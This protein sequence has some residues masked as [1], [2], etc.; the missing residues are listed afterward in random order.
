MAVNTTKIKP[1]ADISGSHILFPEGS[2]AAYL[3]VNEEVADD[4]STYILHDGGGSSGSSDIHSS[5]FKLTQSNMP[6]NYELIAASI[7]LRGKAEAA[8]NGTLVGGSISCTVKMNGIEYSFDTFTCTSSNYSVYLAN[9]SD[10]SFITDFNNYLRTNNKSPEI[11][12]S[13]FTK[14]NQYE[15]GTKGVVWGSVRITQV[16]MSLTYD[17][18]VYRKIGDNWMRV[19]E[20]YRKQNG[21]WFEIDEDEFKSIIQSNL[22]VDKCNL[23]GHIEIPLLDI[24]AACLT[25]GMTGGK[26]CSFCNKILKEHDSILPA[27]GHNSKESKGTATCTEDGMIGGTE[28]S[29]C[30]TVLTEHD[31]VQPALGHNEVTIAGTA[32]CTEDGMQGGTKC[33]RC[34]LTLKE[35]DAVQPALGHNFSNVYTGQCSRCSEYDP[36]SL[37]F[38]IQRNTQTSATTYHFMPNLTWGEW[39]KKDTNNIFGGWKVDVNGSIRYRYTLLGTTDFTVDNV[40]NTDLIIAGHAY[41]ATDNI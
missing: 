11:E 24:P 21:G 12:L 14:P 13:I 39:V 35:H 27:L 36:N 18:G 41:T 23:R 10:Q 9:L 7:S 16:Y 37:T 3:L 29:R 19:T 34:G 20:A 31:A 15:N 8:S 2:S 1:C 38:T 26:K 4:D 25:T 32:T 5:V 33:S 28:C 40:K 6:L 22:L 30:G 17:M